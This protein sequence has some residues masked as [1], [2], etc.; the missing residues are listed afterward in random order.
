MKRLTVI[1]IF[2]L[3]WNWV[4]GQLFTGANDAVGVDEK[5]GTKIPLQL[6]FCDEKGDSITLGEIIDK[7]TILSFVYFDCPSLCSPLQQGISEVVDNCDLEPGTDYEI[8]T[9]S[10]NYTDDPDKAAKKK[11]NFA[12]CVSKNKCEHWFYL[13]GDSLAINTI[14]QAVGYKIKITGLD[15]VHPSGMVIV[16]PT[17]VI[18]RYLYGLTF[19]PFDFKLAI[20]EAQREQPRKTISRVLD[21]CYAY[22]PEG[23]RYTLEITKI[24]ATIIIFFALVLFI[25]WSLNRGKKEKKKRKP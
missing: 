25:N 8:I 10:F 22:D 14:L 6:K 18:T 4:S 20:I 17:G 2:V 23:K 3:S 21:F 16:S 24:S 9:I 5:L 19:L 11:K 15:F 7:P 12:S 13:T 1:L